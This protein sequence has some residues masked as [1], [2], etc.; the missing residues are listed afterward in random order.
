M[1]KKN[2]IV[3][4]CIALLGAYGVFFAE[5]DQ[6]RALF[7]LIVCVNAFHNMVN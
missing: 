5:P 6:M 7:A 2:K 4:I 3:M 1:N